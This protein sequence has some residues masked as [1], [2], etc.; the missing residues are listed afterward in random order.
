MSLK[1]FAPVVDGTRPLVLTTASNSVVIDKFSNEVRIF[2]SGTVTAIVRFGV[3]TTTALVTDMQ[4]PAGAVEIFTIGSS[5][6][7]A[8]I[9]ASGTTT[10]SIT[11]GEGF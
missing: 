4:I 8:G 9:T 5:D 2:N 10:L 7:V 11:P 3:G 6:T 1:S